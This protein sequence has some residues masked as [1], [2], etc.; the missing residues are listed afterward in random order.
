[1]SIQ[2]KIT[3]LEAA[4]TNIATAI[5]DRGG[6]VA[7]GDGFEEFPAAIATIPSGG[8]G[9]SHLKCIHSETFT[10]LPA[11]SVEGSTAPADETPYAIN[12]NFITKSTQAISEGGERY[13][14][15]II[16]VTRKPVEGE[17][18]SDIT[19]WGGVT[20]A[21]AY[22]NSTGG[23]AGKAFPTSQHIDARGTS[24]ADIYDFSAAGHNNAI[25]AGYG[26]LFSVLSGDDNGKIGF[27]R[28]TS[29]TG[30]K[31]FPGGDYIV[32]IFGVETFEAE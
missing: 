6:T 28:K 8:G 27:T 16:S 19:T 11:L 25:I 2:D 29:A 20:F 18:F 1:M 24:T 12:Y 15:F 5:T 26:I 3:R 14:F 32:N 31:F 21:M 17:T 30:L 22:R 9:I 23:N 10:N 7:A 4:K 13:R